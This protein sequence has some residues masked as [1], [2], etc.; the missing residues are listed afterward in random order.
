MDETTVPVAIL[1]RQTDNYIYKM[2]AA[3]TRE[4][5][6]GCAQENLRWPNESFNA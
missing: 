4:S 1:Y 3:G 2:R 5:G 6:C